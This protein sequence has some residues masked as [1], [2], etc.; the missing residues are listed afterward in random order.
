ME[1]Q[2]FL[3]NL[4]QSFRISTLQFCYRQGLLFLCVAVLHAILLFYSINEVSKIS[5]YSLDESEQVSVKIKMIKA[6]EVQKEIVADEKK[7][8]SLQKS[9]LDKVNLKQK[10]KVKK[11][12]KA[13]ELISVKNSLGQK[14]DKAFYL[15]KIR[16]IINAEKKYP[17]TAKRLRHEGELRLE[18]LIDGNGDIIS[19]K[20]L[21]KSKSRI[22]DQATNKLFENVKNFGKTPASIKSLPLKVVVPISYKLI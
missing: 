2:I 19:L 8:Q 4:R 12:V 6:K 15:S 20:Y 16:A 5:H 17:K 10:Y 1:N 22:L 21:K 14:T 11:R 18:L 9:K 3:N 7:T 13:N